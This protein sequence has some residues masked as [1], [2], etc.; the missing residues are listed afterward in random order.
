SG[1]GLALR[2]C[3][4]KNPGDTRGVAKDRD[5]TFPAIPLETHPAVRPPCG[6]GC[7]R[8][9]MACVAPV[10][11]LEAHIVDVGAGGQPSARQCQIR[12]VLTNDWHES[13][14]RNL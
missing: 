12:C 13:S 10:P 8:R 11:I 6:A 2:R 5:V 3:L 14:P 9:R 4:P 1:S 7:E